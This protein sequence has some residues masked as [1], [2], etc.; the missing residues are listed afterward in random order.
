MN[1]KHIVV[2]FITVLLPGL[3]AAGGKDTFDKGM[4]PILKS[5]LKIHHALVADGTAGVKEA[6]TAIAMQA[7]KVDASSV[8]GEHAAHYKDL[9]KNLRAAAEKLARA[10]SIELAR[11][12]FKD[13]SKPM[14]MWG[15]M[16]KPHGVVVMFCSMAKA[17]WL[18]NKGDVKNPY[19]GSKMLGCGEVVGG[20]SSGT[21]SGGMHHHGMKH[22][23]HKRH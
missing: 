5:Y 2:V 4:Q 15:T 16:S 11:E 12:A 22:G 1:L 17:S 23:E 8:T 21:A 6:A 13:L 19:Y 18:Q 9:P 14:A 10:S 20:D 7:K 3:A